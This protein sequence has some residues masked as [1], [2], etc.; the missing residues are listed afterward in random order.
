MKLSRLKYVPATALSTLAL[1]LTNAGAFAQAPETAANGFKISPLRQDFTIEKGSSQKLTITLTNTASVKI[2]AKPVINDFIASSDESGDPRV[3]LEENSKSS[4]NSFKNL[5]APMENFEMGPNE[6]KTLD[7]I[8][9]VPANAP[10]GG[11]YGAV[12]FAPA[13]SDTSKIVALTASVGTL[14]LV[15]VPGSVTEKAELV[16]IGA[17]NVLTE[18]K[19]GKETKKAGTIGSLFSSGPIAIVVRLK[20]SGNVHVQP[21]GKITVKN[22]SGKEVEGYEFNQLG[23]AAQR[24]NILPDST[25]RFENVLKNDKWFGKYTVEAN[26][27]YAQ[28]SGDLISAKFSFWVIPT[29]VFIVGAAVLF[30]L[31]A[32]A[33]LFFRKMTNKKR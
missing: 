30:A 14:V 8:V 23:D 3:L 22:S 11:Y 21:F 6:V 20:N 28:G 19:D 12:R 27:G 4:G 5:V 9:S 29:W 25:R 26:L 13:A 15:R 33:F 1:L 18:S 32:G 31:A 24:S 16:E 10:A 7:I 2:I 17:A